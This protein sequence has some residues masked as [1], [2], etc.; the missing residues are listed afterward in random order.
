MTLLTAINGPAP[1]VS[2]EFYP[3]RDAA[4]V[5]ALLDRARALD[6][7]RPDFV[8]VT[9]G[10]GGGGARG[11]AASIRAT[12]ELASVTG[13]ARVAHLTLVGQTRDQ[14]ADSV[15]SFDAAGIDG[16]LALRGD[17]PG[18]PGAPWRQVA[19]GL[20][21]ASE[22]VALIRELTGAPVG[23]AAFPHGHPAAESLDRDAAV[24]AAKQAAGA[25]FALTQVVFEPEAYFRLVERARRAGATLPI[26]PGVMPVTAAAKVDK[27][28]AYS[29]A[30]LPGGLR[31]RLDAAAGPG[32]REA[33]GID[34]SIALARQLLD[35]GAPGL[36]LYTLNSSD[37][38]RA[39]CGAL[40]VL[41]RAGEK[42]R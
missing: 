20:R 4:G 42:R 8:S 23:V 22:L 9:Y 2:F 17:P 39:V 36:H 25:S 29:G 1:S 7:L 16:F 5:G 35:G 31:R 37:A 40:P 3:P 38:A 26:V 33:V 32:E 12:T 24:L 34:W 27:L 13:A 28:E 41:A 11:E 14:L 19:G 6:S 10:A 30:P 15:R 18:G 21:Y